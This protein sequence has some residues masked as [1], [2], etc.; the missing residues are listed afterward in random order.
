VNINMLRDADNDPG[1][2]AAACAADPNAVSWPGCRVY[3]SADGGTT[4]ASLLTVPSESTMGRTTTVLGNFYGGNVRDELSSV[5]VVMNNG[6]LASTSNAGLRA[7]V[8]MAVC[9]D[10]ILF[11]RDATLQMNG[12]YTLRGFLRGRRGSEYAKGSHAVGERFVLV[13]PTTFVRV[14]QS[15]ADIGIAKLYKAVTS[16]MSIAGA[17][18]QA[19]TNLGTGLMPYAPSHLGGGRDASDNATLKCRRRNRISGEW[20]N[21]V[22]VPMSEETEAYSWDIFSDIS[23]TTVLRT[24]TSSTPSV[25]YSAANQTAD[26]ITPGSPIY[27]GVAQMST[28]VGRGHMAYGSI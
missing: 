28:V 7:G 25:A 2:Y 23:Y 6:T 15:T 18:A 9:G 5:N 19:F 22:N 26:G 14:P 3:V 16:G 4:Y 13:D 17:S 24:L 27:F 8:N 1:F 12:S 11:F 20:R 10:E 21:G